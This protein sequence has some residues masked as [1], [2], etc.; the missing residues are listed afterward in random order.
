MHALPD[1]HALGHIHSRAA[2]VVLAELYDDAVAV[3][4]SRHRVLNRAEA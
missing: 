1:E 4:C 3:S 2:D